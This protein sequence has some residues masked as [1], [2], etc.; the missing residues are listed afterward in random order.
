MYLIRMVYIFILYLT[1][2]VCESNGTHCPDSCEACSETGS[3]F[4]CNCSKGAY[5]INGGCAPC[6]T[7]GV[8]CERCSNV[9][10]CEEC[11]PGKWGPQCINECGTGCKDGKCNFKDGS[12]ACIQE[13]YGSD[14]KNQCS[15]NCLS[16]TCLDNGHC[17]CTQGHYLQTCSAPCLSACEE[18]TNSSSCTVCPFG[19]FG[20]SCQ[21]ECQ[22]SN[23]TSCNII[24]GDCIARTCPQ[25]CT[26]CV[27][28]EHCTGCTVGWFGRTC[29]YACSSN[30]FGGCVQSSGF[31]NACSHR[32]FGSSCDRECS[33]CG[34][35]NC[36]QTGECYKCYQGFY[37]T[38]CN[39]TCPS[40]CSAKC[41]QKDG[42]CAFTCPA[43]CLNCSDSLTCTKCKD[44]FYGYIC[45]EKCSSMCKQGI[46]DMKSGHCIECNSSLYYGDF[47]NTTCSSACSANG[48]V[49]QTGRC[50]GCMGKTGYGPSC[51]IT[52]N[53]NCKYQM[54]SQEKGHC[55]D[56]CLP[57]Y[58][59]S[60]CDNVCSENCVSS[61]TESN[62][63][64]KGKCLSGCIDGFIGDM[65]TTGSDTENGQ[66]EAYAIGGGVGG[67]GLLTVVVVLVVVVLKRRRESK[68][69][70]DRSE[71]TDH[72]YHTIERLHGVKQGSIKAPTAR[73]LST[74]NPSYNQAASDIMMLDGGLETPTDDDDLEIDLD[75]ERRS[76]KRKL[77]KKVE[78]NVYYIGIQ[79]IEK[80]KVKVDELAAFVAGKTLDYYE[81]E[82]D[83]F[84]DGLLRSCDAAKLPHNRAKN[85]Y[86]GLYAYD[87][88]RVKVAGF[89]TDYINA[90][91]I[92]GFKER[93]AYIASLGPMSKQMGDFAM[94][95]NMIWQQKVEKIVMVTNLMEE[96]KEKC[97]QYWPNVWI[98]INYSG[99]MVTCQHE[100]EYADFTRRL[101][102]L[103]DGKSERQLHH[104]H[105]TA[106]PDRGIP[107]DVTALI[108]FRHRV[109]H[110]PAHLGGPTL[111][112]YEFLHLALVYTLTLNSEQIPRKQFQ[113]YMI[114]TNKGNLIT[115]FKAFQANRKYILA[116]SPMPN[117]VQ[118]FLTLAY[119]EN[120]SC[121]VS[122]EQSDGTK[123]MGE[124]NPADNQV[125]KKGQLSV[126]CGRDKVANEYSIQK[127]LTIEFTGSTQAQFDFCHDCVLE[128]VRSFKTYSN[129]GGN[130]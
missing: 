53:T 90:N 77:A 19:K 126:A 3:N 76:Q 119:Q 30:C 11:F 70:K 7:F 85:R 115:Q 116:Q 27:D 103:N 50:N 5:Y 26:S 24:T 106:W 87:A 12:C 123:D 80:R 67:V 102:L 16:S 84:S 23:K 64:T 82:F 43:N 32:Y 55:T 127:G 114:E 124:Y 97:E 113:N 36:T 69:Y 111:E 58:Y 1:L 81:E 75:E 105:F 15:Q 45:N 118:D 83:K 86:K 122:F 71:E 9:S 25:T 44:F 18:C 112:Q 108:E 38:F 21:N 78:E 104:L 79:D 8:N 49:R 46:C 22:C 99:V 47:C 39:S 74:I 93:N 56:G 33:Y 129:I 2:D 65:C 31:C 107:E 96:G 28:S 98:T 13:Y 60:T 20:N 40:T 89:E 120:C 52:C 62:C 17:N 73:S 94:F 48:C 42:S 57:N 117:T 95:W 6:R 54:C 100:N 41:N 61:I 4:V 59:G 109:L 91:Y 66:R 125:L 92:D 128:F 68:P 29:S 110:S 14:C 10:Q 63:D 51:N 72:E 35:S 37:G 130:I 121:I 101:L 34:D 88:T